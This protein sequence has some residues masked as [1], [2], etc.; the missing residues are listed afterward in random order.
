MLVPAG[1][2]WRGCNESIDDRCEDD[3]NRYVALNV[4]Y[5]EIEL[6]EFWIDKYEVTREA[7]EVCIAGGTCTAP[8]LLPSADESLAN[9]P[10][11]GVSWT[12]ATAYCET[13]GKRLPTE[14]EWEKAA[15]GKDGRRYSWGNEHPTCG[16]AHLLY[17][18][19]CP[20]IR[21]PLPVDAFPTDVSPYGVIGM[22]GN[23]QEWVQD[24]NG[25]TYYEVAPAI[26]PLGPDASDFLTNQK[27]TRGGYWDWPARPADATSV[28][29][30][31]W[32]N[33]DRGATRVG[34]R[35][36]STT[37]PW[38]RPGFGGS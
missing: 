31:R 36:A 12:Q 38:P 10:V 22:I 30:R 1:P 2:F 16:H 14:A 9:L 15:R 28:S 17:S 8:L 27:I 33:R 19:P 35:C 37:P 3:V 24:W 6:S 23:V 32:L 25:Q 29:L 11:S 7:Y 4:P 21:G 26:D 20:R 18:E 34:F 13:V 5:R